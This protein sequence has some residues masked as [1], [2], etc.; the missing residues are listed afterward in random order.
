MSFESNKKRK[1]QILSCGNCHKKKR[2]C[3]RK[4]P[5]SS[6]IKLSIDATCA[7]STISNKKQHSYDNHG[8]NFEHLRKP[9]VTN[10][11]ELNIENDPSLH[12]KIEI[13]NNKIKDLEASITIAT[14]QNKQ[15]S[16]DSRIQYNND[17][18]SQKRYTNIGPE[19]LKDMK[20]LENDLRFTGYNPIMADEYTINF[21][22]SINKD[23]KSDMKAVFTPYGPLGFSIL[24]KQD[25][26]AILIWKYLTSPNRIHFSIEPILKRDPKDK[27][28]E[29][30]DRRSRKFYGDKYIKILDKKHSDADITE[31][32]KAISNFGLK[33]G[34]S[35]HPA[36]FHDETTLL[37]RIRQVLPN[38]R[39]LNMLVDVFFDTLYPFFP[40][41]DESAFRADI[42]R[43]TGHTISDNLDEEIEDIVL[44]SKHDIAF[45]ATLLITV[46]LSYLSLF[47][48]LVDKNEELLN[49][50]DDS[51]TSQN[52]RFLMEH[53]IPIELISIAE[54][55]I[56][57]FDLL[58]E[59]NLALFQSL[60]MMHIYHIH[61][62]EED[63]SSNHQSSISIGIL[64]QMANSLFLNRDPDYI[65]YFSERKIDKRLKI[66]KRNL[67][68][69]LICADIKDSIIYGTPIYTIES[70]FDTKKPFLIEDTSN[71]NNIEKHTIMAFD[72]L[73]PVFMSAHKIL[74]HIFRIKSDMKISDLA[75]RL[76]DF[77]ILIE[78]TL[79]N[80][81]EYLVPDS[82][83]PEFLKIQK[84]NLYVY[85][86]LMLL[87]IY[88]CFFLYFENR[89]VQLNLFY[90]KKLWAII[91]YEL[92]DISSNFLYY[93]EDYFGSGFALIFTPIFEYLTRMRMLSCQFQVRLKITLR[94]IDMNTFVKIPMSSSL[95]KLYAKS[96]NA[97]IDIINEVEMRCEDSIS[98][99]SERYF[100]AWKTTHSYKYGRSILN[101]DTLYEVDQESSLNANLKYSLDQ[102]QQL[103]DLLSCCINV[104]RS[105]PSNAFTNRA[106][107]RDSTRNL[108][109]L[110][111]SEERVLIDHQ[112]DKLWYLFD[113]IKQEF[114]TSRNRI[115]VYDQ[116]NTYPPGSLHPEDSNAGFNFDFDSHILHEN[117][118]FGNFAIDD[119]FSDNNF[120]IIN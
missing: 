76:S 42:S 60:C 56:K 58:S 17:H 39:T 64:Y 80:L 7:Y 9:G 108:H 31:I 26:G 113:L 91:N 70:N 21:L 45:L 23:P 47:S 97:L 3:D 52:R 66:L 44:G 94:S 63:P 109:I 59:S 35:F 112:I 46:R 98:T 82:Y 95:V 24:L 85:C 12:N 10:S 90:F 4:H 19:S 101:D 36:V 61:A 93:C 5:C 99:L 83:Y 72:K 84:F 16:N 114:L 69:F 20:N 100:Y 13:L 110:P 77:E 22:E 89:N 79:G 40:I 27:S 117:N 11:E 88:Y 81:K 55:C 43:M 120:N 51:L 30:L 103:K 38:R 15:K 14:L 92:G 2:K 33:L 28:L 102:I 74:K 73:Y 68:Y 111:S 41:L 67:W 50:K 48:N 71:I 32:K 25:P 78:E 49:S 104:T 118:L 119:F 75:K 37:E 105:K 116:R 62:P 87:Y 96:L 106:G 34:I 29:D 107:Y 1:R 8:F 54:L 86:K 18:N 115:S 57:E 65:L 53:P 6:C